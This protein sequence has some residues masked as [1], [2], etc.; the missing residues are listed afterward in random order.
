MNAVASQQTRHIP[1]TSG[2][3]RG[4][5]G[6]LIGG[7]AMA[8]FSM[9]VAI[10]EDGFWAPV[11]GITSVVFGDEHYGGGFEFWPV[12]VG[13]MG[14]MMNSVV[15]GAVFALV[16]AALL[17]RASTALVIGAGMAFGLMVWLV[18]VPGVAAQAQSSE[19][20]VDS[21][22]AWAWIAGHLMFGAITAAVFA[23]GRRSD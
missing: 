13:A 11:R 6:G 17:A 21:V 7:M 5:F 20:F 10:S 2:L 16:A 14:H 1:I 4:A 9:L 12:V 15:L 23:L 8:M 19:L 3:A 22:P 18:M